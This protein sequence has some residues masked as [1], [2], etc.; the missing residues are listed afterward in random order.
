MK[1]TFI[2]FCGMFILTFLLMSASAKAENPLLGSWVFDVSQ[3]P[4]EYSKGKVIFEQEEEKEMTGKIVFDSGVEV[5]LNKITTEDEK[6]IFEV[7]LEGMHVKTI[8]ALK[9][10]NITGHVETYE[11]NMPFSAKR[12]VPED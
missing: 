5:K 12:F 11:G 10:D 2:T 7:Y 6:I 3:A 4:Y 9:D 1:R 8:V